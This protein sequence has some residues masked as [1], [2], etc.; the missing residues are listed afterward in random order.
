MWVQ[1]ERTALCKNEVIFFVQLDL[2]RFA[3]Q[4]VY[5]S[6]P[7]PETT[8]ISLVWTMPLS[9]PLSFPFGQVTLAALGNLRGSDRL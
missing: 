7:R 9:F 3:L 5:R 4:D 8:H 2:Q 6:P 1:H